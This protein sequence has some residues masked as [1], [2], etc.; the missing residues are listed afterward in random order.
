MKLFTFFLLFFL[1]FT[2]PVF[3]QVTDVT[4][5][6]HP[7]LIPSNLYPGY[8][9]AEYEILAD[10]KDIY[11]CRRFGTSLLYSS[12]T[13]TQNA[14][15]LYQSCWGAYMTTTFS[16]SPD[17]FV[18]GILLSRKVTTSY[19]L[20]TD[21]RDGKICRL[22]TKSDPD[23]AQ[24]CNGTINVAYLVKYAFQNKFPLDLFTGFNASFNP[25][26]CPSFTI[27]NQTFQLCYLNKLVAS[28]KYVL[29]VIFIIS[30]V[31]ML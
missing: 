26:P 23:E 13:A 2:T 24:V 15:I 28:L 25:T 19:S 31:I 29:L 4:P 10:N 22:K 6:Y 7:N 12:M 3:A 27:R 17:A 8:C 20:P 30:S 5:D 9:I 11:T 18:H 16:G 14:N 21:H 1:I